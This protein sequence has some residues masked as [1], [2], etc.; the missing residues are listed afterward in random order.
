MYW[1]TV[2]Q[3][4]GR[5]EVG[6]DLQEMMII[7]NFHTDSDIGLFQKCISNIKGLSSHISDKHLQ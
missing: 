3:S 4:A 2:Y 7:T 5:V 6:I 1:L